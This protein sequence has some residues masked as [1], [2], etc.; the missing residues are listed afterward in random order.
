MKKIFLL[1]LVFGFAAISS[2]GQ[3]AENAEHVSPLLIGSTMPDAELKAPDKTD[4]KFSAITSGKPTVVIFYRGG[5]C[6]F[7]NAHLAG[8]QAAQSEVIRLGYQIVAIS[9][10]SPENLVNTVEK[11]KLQYSLYSDAEGKFIQSIGIAFKA[12]EKYSG[13][14]LKNSDGLNS[15]FLPVPSVFILNSAGKIKFEYVNP[16]YKDR[17]TAGLLLA[18]LKEIVEP[19]LN[20]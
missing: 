1:S 12:P 4:H 14:L 5:W 13:M 7:C 17:M 3:I 9:P 10:D 18:V 15:G 19:V 11:D 8:I 6:P 2:F 20:K 16:D